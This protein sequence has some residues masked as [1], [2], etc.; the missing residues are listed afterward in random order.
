MTELLVHLGSSNR[1][2]GGDNQI[3]HG[4]DGTIDS[5]TRKKGLIQTAF[6]TVKRSK[7]SGGTS[8]GRHGTRK[9]ES[10]EG[11]NK[12]RERKIDFVAESRYLISK[13]N[14]ESPCFPQLIVATHGSPRC[15]VYG[16]VRPYRRATDNSEW[17]RRTDRIL[18][19]LSLRR[20]MQS[21]HSLMLLKTLPTFFSHA[22]Q[23]FP[24]WMAP[25][26]RIIPFHHSFTMRP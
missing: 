9:K 3:M 1:D 23:T 13:R 26:R 11:R 14:E 7:S 20:R 24:H 5:G 15:I 19:F 18:L 2:T 6:R 12:E 16:P 8:V 21:L 25:S 10:R 4:L 17:Q 22:T